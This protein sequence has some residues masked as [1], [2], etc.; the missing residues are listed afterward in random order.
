MGVPSASAAVP[1]TTTLPALSKNG[2]VERSERGA[3][4]TRLRL[5][6]PATVHHI[7]PRPVW[8]DC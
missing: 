8:P 6:Y 1:R 2:A 7:D 5:A 3:I 4:S